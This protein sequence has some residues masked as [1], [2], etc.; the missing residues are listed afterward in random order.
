MAIVVETL[1]EC[2]LIDK[3]LLIV[4]RAEG[5]KQKQRESVYDADRSQKE[6]G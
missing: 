1:F 4:V 3:S 6:L 2:F 5:K